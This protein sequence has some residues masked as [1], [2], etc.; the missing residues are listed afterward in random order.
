MPLSTPVASDSH[1]KR[2]QNRRERA[3]FPVIAIGASAGGLEALE[4]FF[5]SAG[6][7][8]GAAYVV[9]Q[10]LDPDHKGMMP[11]LLQRFTQ[12][13]VVQAENLMKV[14]PGYVYVIPP[15]SDLSILHDRLYLMEPAERR[16]LRLPIDFFF[17]SLADDRRETAVGVLLSGMGSDGTLGAAAIKQHGGLVL[18]QDPATAKFDG[19]PRSAVDSGQVDIVA[20]ATELPAR[21]KRCLQHPA[22]LCSD[23]DMDKHESETHKSALDKVCIV[24]RAKTGHDFSLYKRSTLYRRIERR[25][26]IHQLPRIADYVRYLRETPQEIDLLFREK[27]KDFW[28]LWLM[29]KLV[30]SESMNSRALPYH[31]IAAPNWRSA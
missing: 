1:E 22:G 11:E 14:R 31:S 18:V 19:M 5:A 17:R 26:A 8:S 15:N 9:I 2:H 23:A 4:Q 3:T 25:M 7:V 24:L 28:P 12:L 30:S 13:P 16:G 20:P 21:I 6:I 29:E 10:H 27:E